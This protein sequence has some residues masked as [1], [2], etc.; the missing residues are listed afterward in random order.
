MVM[1]FRISYTLPG[2]KQILQGG[3]LMW[4]DAEVIERRCL[5]RAGAVAKVKLFL[6]K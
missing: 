6:K 2:A 4:N 5:D 3:R 1:F